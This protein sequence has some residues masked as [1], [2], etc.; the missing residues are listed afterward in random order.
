M[1]SP[2]SLDFALGISRPF[3]S[4]FT[5]LTGPL[6]LTVKVAVSPCLTVV[7]TRPWTISGFPALGFFSSTFCS[8][9]SLGRRTVKAADESEVPSSFDTST[10][11]LKMQ[12]SV[13][14]LIASFKWGWWWC[15][16]QSIQPFTTLKSFRFQDDCLHITSLDIE[17]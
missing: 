4:H 16:F 13:W 10:Y 15:A 17:I 11:M 14:T 12:R 5:P 3:F 1:P 2:R 8:L 9:G 6:T 7:G